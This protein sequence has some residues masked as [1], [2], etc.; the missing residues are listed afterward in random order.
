MNSLLRALGGFALIAATSGC[1]TVASFQTADT[2]GRGRT[3]IALEA[4]S[5]GLWGSNEPMVHFGLGQA[6]AITK[7]EVHWPSGQV[8]TFNNLQVRQRLKVVQQ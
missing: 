1:L 2:N 8:Q 4:G 6:L 3:Q 7:L 5:T